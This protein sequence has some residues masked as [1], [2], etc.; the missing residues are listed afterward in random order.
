MK[1]LV[2]GGCGFIGG[3]FV[4]YILNKYPDYKIINLDKLTYAGNPD[5]LKDIEGNSNYQF[6]KGDICDKELTEELIKKVEVVIN[7][8]AESHVDRSI[9]SPDEFVNTNVLGVNNLL[10]ISHK[11]GISKFI[12]ISTDEVYGSIE[13]GSFKET[14]ML[15]PSS[16]YSASKAGGD[17]IAYSYWVTFKL[18]VII[19]R[20]SNNFGPY[21][22]P[23]KLIPLFITNLLEDKPVPLYG[24]GMNVRDWLYV[25]DNCSAIDAV[26]HK[27]KNGEIYNI[28][29]G[30][31]I[32]NIEI[33]KK[34]LNGLGKP[35]NLIN[36][37]EDRLGHDR[38][39]SI[40]SSKVR[41]LG[42]VSEYTFESAITET[43]KWYKDNVWWWQK[44]KKALT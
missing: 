22:Y 34:V 28:G 2:T 30:N 8:A 40:D 19:T 10:R 5:N 26:L 21:Q 39:Y 27:G 16:P 44:L 35:E 13:N 33:T 11:A 41:K 42:W 7:F 17:L 37:V 29:G 25:I 9:I 6:V 32:P 38:R 1:I 31:E 18:P 36:Y 15:S 14:D 43:I 3:N 23:E 24:D 20:S 12:Q 4:R